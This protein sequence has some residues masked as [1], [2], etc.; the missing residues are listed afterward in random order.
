M[1]FRFGGR[2]R[3]M[4]DDS[5]W[6][7]NFNGTFTFSSIEQYQETLLH[8]PGG[9]A[10]QFTIDT[11]NPQTNAKRFDFS[12]FVGDDWRIRPNLTLNMGLR[13]ESQTNIHDRLDVAPRFGFALGPR[14]HA[15]RQS[16]TVIRGGYGFFY[17]RLPLANSVTAL[18]YNGI[19]Q[20]QYVITNPDFFPN[21]PSI[22]NQ[23]ELFSQSTN[24]VDSHYIRPT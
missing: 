6:L 1:L 16:K 3:L 19:V 8:E 17:V 22:D 21:I 7:Q 12:E 4:T 11:G 5:Y 15:N 24:E 14:R 13:F 18:R 20:Q 2:L 10:A 23:P 9:G